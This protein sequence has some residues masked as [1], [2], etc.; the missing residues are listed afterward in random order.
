[1]LFLSSSCQPVLAVKPRL[2]YPF[3]RLDKALI[4]C[5]FITVQPSY[6]EKLLAHFHLV[7]SMVRPTRPYHALSALPSFPSLNS[8]TLSCS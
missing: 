4:E 2:P 1:M 3:Q 6:P 8:F 7:R 5:N